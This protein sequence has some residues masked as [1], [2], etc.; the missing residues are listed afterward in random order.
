MIECSNAN[1]NKCVVCDEI[2]RCVSGQKIIKNRQCPD[3][4]PDALT[5]DYI[6]QRGEFDSFVKMT[7]REVRTAS[8]AYELKI[9]Q[10]RKELGLD[11]I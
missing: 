11:Q 3:R 8:R 7:D 1:F 6:Y 9:G 10:M 2:H 4:D 5:N